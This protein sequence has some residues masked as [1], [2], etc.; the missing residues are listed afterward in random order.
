MGTNATHTTMKTNRLHN[1][2]TQQIGWFLIVALVP[3][4]IMG[5]VALI[6]AKEA[7][8]R[9]IL[10]ELSYV[11]EIRKHQ[12]NDF[13]AE[14]RHHL[15]NIVQSGQLITQFRHHQQGHYQPGNLL[16]SNPSLPTLIQQWGM[17]NLILISTEGLILSN[18]RHPEQIGL[19]LREEFY[20]DSVLT[21]SFEEVVATETISSPHHG[22]FEPY[23]HFSTFITAPIREHNRIIGM[24]AAEI[25]MNRLSLILSPRNNNDTPNSSGLLLATRGDSGV[26]LLHL[27]WEVP[28]PDDACISYRREY[29]DKLP[30]MRALR[31][32]QGAGWNID[33]ACEP[34]LVT[35][36]PLKNLNL[37]M[38][39]FKTEAE[40]L[41]TVD[42]LRTILFQTG[43]VAVLFALLLAFLVSLPL[44]RPLLQLTHITRNITHGGALKEARAELPKEV[45][46]NEIRELSDSIGK[47][48]TTIDNHTQDLEEYQQNLE[49]HVYYRTAALKKSQKAA[50]EANRS[51]GEFLARMSHEIRTP[52]NGIVGLAELLGETPLN[53]QQQRY[54]DSLAISSH[55]LSELLNNILDFSKIE[56]HKFTINEIPFS[57][58]EIIQQI[59]TIVQM[60]AE[61]KGLLFNSMVQPTIPQR[62]IG[63][64]KVF[65]QVLLNLLSNAIKYT[66]KGRIDLILTLE[67]DGDSEI[68]LRIRV[69]DT[70]RGIPLDAQQD[71]FSNAF[72]RHHEEEENAP[73]GTGLGL[74]ITQS[75]VEQMEGQ[76]WVQSTEGEGSEFFILLPL[77]VAPKENPLIPKQEIIEHPAEHPQYTILLADD[78]DIN[79]LVIENYL[80]DAG[81][82]V[83]I[84]E[85]GIEAVEAY[86]KE[87]VDLVLMDIRMPKMNGLE[88]IRQIRGYER[89]ENLDITP[90]IAMTADVLQETHDKAMEMGASEWLPKPASREQLDEML[91]RCLNQAPLS[92]AADSK[93][94]LDPLT[95]MFVQDSLGKLELIE[96]QL[97]QRSWNALAE[98]AHAIKGNALILGFTR[99]GELMAQIQLEAEQQLAE[100]ILPLLQQFRQQM[101]K[102]KER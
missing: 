58:P 21:Q 69:C 79:R 59:S 37:G 34:I 49:H 92:R 6:L 80:N 76:I 75:L 29:L 54:V 90:I 3:L 4:L 100:S 57:L 25:D 47:M 2:T 85:N 98:T 9:E 83:V 87:K 63:D 8:T 33:T 82:Q 50:E 41:A 65:R 89:L 55:H 61:S 72:N 35:W 48:L 15:L 77:K 67:I 38:T 36:Q 70:G 17:K 78:S 88:A 18:L 22:Y 24:A 28:Q 66:D 39:L 97:Q 27:D 14:R 68:T 84:A 20:S 52:L 7:I 64:P 1:L 30:M 99:M 53:E 96:R 93:V 16:K 60:D 26:S 5:S 56:A 95:V 74:T 40:A 81:H 23:E 32:E 12:V 101:D 51:K 86:T 94:E 42:Q 46:I 102:L 10:Q 13:F 43:S 44:I 11:S 91:L 45:R 19:N 31:G 71:L 62:L 73:D